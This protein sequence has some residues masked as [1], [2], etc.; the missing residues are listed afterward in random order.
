MYSDFFITSNFQTGAAK[1]EQAVKGK[2]FYYVVL[3]RLF[4]PTKRKGKCI[5][6][7]INYSI[8]D[9]CNWYYL[10]DINTKK[11]FSIN[12]FYVNLKEIK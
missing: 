12:Q 4:M 2:I 5:I 10:K 3:D 8:S 9:D 7:N 11:C 1:E 6:T